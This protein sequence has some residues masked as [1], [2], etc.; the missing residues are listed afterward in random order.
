MFPGVFS[1]GLMLEPLAMRGEGPLDDGVTAATGAI[2][3]NGIKI[4]E[5]KRFEHYNLY[6]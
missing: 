6:S 5:K 1:F 4:S 2:L 3:C